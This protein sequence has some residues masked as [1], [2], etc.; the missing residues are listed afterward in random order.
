MAVLTSPFF[1]SD[2][3]CEEEQLSRMT[4]GHTPLRNRMD[5]DSLY[6]SPQRTGHFRTFGPAVGRWDWRRILKNVAR[7]SK[8]PDL[9]EFAGRNVIRNLG[10]KYVLDLCVLPEHSSIQPLGSGP[11]TSS[12][13]QIE[14]HGGPYDRR[15]SYDV[16]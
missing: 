10:R 9:L 16:R 15:L 8:L 2:E 6:I 12:D 13:S 5:L 3:D 11:V 14:S 4:G 1:L 7:L